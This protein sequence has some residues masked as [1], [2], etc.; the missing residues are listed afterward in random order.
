[1]AD[2]LE[3]ICGFDSPEAVQSVSTCPP[4]VDCP[5]HMWELCAM[6][7]IVGNGYN[8]NGTT[9][10]VFNG[11]PA[12]DTCN[13][14][15]TGPTIPALPFLGSSYAIGWTTPNVSWEGR[16]NF[17]GNPFGNSAP[18]GFQPP[19][20]SVAAGYGPGADG[21]P[22]VS[23]WDFFY[24][25]VVSQVGGN[26][27]IGDRI[28]FDICQQQPAWYVPA[29]S[30]ATHPTSGVCGS[31][32]FGSY[33]QNWNKICLIYKGRKHWPNHDTTTIS[34]MA[35]TAGLD[36]LCCS[37]PSFPST[38]SCN[39][40]AVKGTYPQTRLYNYDA[41]NHIETT[42]GIV[43]SPSDVAIYGNK[44]YNFT[45]GTAFPT[46][47]E[48][49]VDFTTNSLTFIRDIYPAGGWVQSLVGI[50]ECNSYTMKSPNEII[51]QRNSDGLIRVIDIGNATTPATVVSSFTMNVPFN[52][53][54]P[55]GD[56]YYYPPQY[57]VPGMAD[58][59]LVSVKHQTKNFLVHLD[60]SGNIL[61]SLDIGAVDPAFPIT[62][63]DGIYYFDGKT[64]GTFL[65]DPS[66]SYY[67][68]CE[69]S[70]NPLQLST[71]V[72]MNVVG[73]QG[74]DS[75]C[76][77]APIPDPIDP[78]PDPCFEIGDISDPALGGAGGMI[79]ATP[80]SFGNP[81][82]YYYE[83]ALDDLSIGNT[84]LAHST[85]LA[86][87]DAEESCGIASANTAF[88]DFK[89]PWQLPIDPNIPNNMCRWGFGLNSFQPGITN[90]PPIGLPA[91]VNIG[92]PVQALDSNA[93]QIYPPG[94]V[95]EEIH[96]IPGPSAT[97]ITLN[98]GV[99]QTLQ[100]LLQA[101]YL[102]VFNNNAVASIPPFS[103]PIKIL[104]TG[105]TVAGGPF[106]TTGAEW[107]A[108]GQ[109]LQFMPTAFDTGHTNTQDIITFPAAPVWPTHDIAAE[110]CA[111]HQQLPTGY[112]PEKWFLPSL[113]E[114]DLMFQNVGPATPFGVTLQLQQ[115]F[116]DMQDVY[117]TSSDVL[118][119]GPSGTGF[120][121]AWAYCTHDPMVPWPI[122]TTPP[123]P[124]GPFMAKRCSTL[125]VRPIR[126]FECQETIPAEPHP[127]RYQ[128]CD[129]FVKAHGDGWYKPLF[130]ALYS[131]GSCGSGWGTFN[132]PYF[133]KTTP[134][135]RLEAVIG[136]FQYSMQLMTTD[137]AGNQY[138]LSDFDDANNPDG[139]TISIWEADGTYLGAWHYQ[140]VVF[141]TKV[142]NWLK[143]AAITNNFSWYDQIPQLDDPTQV[144]SRDFPD[145]MAIEFAN[146]THVDG[147]HEIVNYGY[148][149]KRS[150]TLTPVTDED[151]QRGQR[152]VAGS[153]NGFSG[154]QIWNE[155]GGQGFSTHHTNYVNEYY[156][157]A[158][159]GKTVSHAYIQI[160]CAT[161][162][163]KPNAAPSV[164]LGSNTVFQHK[165][166]VCAKEVLQ[167]LVGKTMF[168]NYPVTN[169]NWNF[170]K[171][172]GGHI[173]M[174]GFGGGMGGWGGG[175]A[176][177]FMPQLNP[178]GNLTFNLTYGDTT[179]NNAPGTAIN[180]QPLDVWVPNS[181]ILP[182]NGNDAYIAYTAG[183]AAAAADGIYEGYPKHYLFCWYA[184][185]PPP[186]S[187][188]L[189]LYSNLTTALDA[190]NDPNSGAY[191][192]Q[193]Q[194]GCEHYE[195]GD[196]GPAGGIIVAV[197]YMNIN[198]PATGTVGPVVAPLQGD[199][200]VQ[201][202]TNY[203]YE[204]S[205]VNLNVEDD[206][207][208]SPPTADY[209]SWGSYDGFATIGGGSDLLST[210]PIDYTNLWLADMTLY[211]VPT[212]SL[213][214]IVNGP[215]GVA[216]ELVGQ[217]EIVH[218][219]MIFAN[220][221]NPVV[222][223]SGVCNQNITYNNETAFKACEIY[224]LNGYSDWF[225]PSVG[226]M[227]F[228][229]NYT[230]PGTLYDS[231]ATGVS[232]SQSNTWYDSNAQLQTGSAHYWTCNS[233]G[234]NNTDHYFEQDQPFANNLV[235]YNYPTG[236]LWWS[237]Y[238]MQD[239]TWAGIPHDANNCN[240]IAYSVSLDPLVF[241]NPPA[242]PD[243]Q[244]WK[245][246]SRRGSQKH[247]IRAMRKFACGSPETPPGIEYSF[248]Y[249]SRWMSYGSLEQKSPGRINALQSDSVPPV[250]PPIFDPS[251]PGYQEHVIGDNY[252]R[253]HASKYDVVGNQ[254]FV[255][256][257][258]LTNNMWR[259]NG[260]ADPQ[261]VKFEVYSQHEEHLGTWDYDVTGTG[262]CGVDTCSLAVDLTLIS[263]PV[264]VGGQTQVNLWSPSNSGPPGPHLD[265]PWM[266]EYCYIKVT[267]NATRPNNNYVGMWPPIYGDTADLQN[268]LG[269]GV[270]NRTLPGQSVSNSWRAICG[271]CDEGTSYSNQ[272]CE[273]WFAHYVP[274]GAYPLNAS[275]STCLTVNT[276]TYCVPGSSI[277]DPNDGESVSL[278]TFVERLNN[279][280]VAYWQE[281]YKNKSIS[282]FLLPE[283]EKV[284][285]RGVEEEIKEKIE[286]EEQKEKEE[287]QKEQEQKEKEKQELTKEKI[288][289]LKDKKY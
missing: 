154:T 197:P 209:P 283:N 287:Q 262:Q 158:W 261:T 107:G 212:G 133:N 35:A 159:G 64:V 221:S 114:F 62:T 275:L 248:R 42:I 97:S 151:A 78:R 202:P 47:K 281:E 125:S 177:A 32:S 83:V 8:A 134:L 251:T 130:S 106:S 137:V 121:Y 236:G 220:G 86:T 7:E 203:Y 51:M 25:W 194:E 259:S 253:F 170:N 92:D 129:A 171:K 216:S 219:A 127:D 222:V 44:V 81:T 77:D 84:P 110:L 17:H 38:A 48:Y 136:G 227:D 144:T 238:V 189:T 166:V 10:T 140:N 235:S 104:S 135:H 247:N 239:F 26:L 116:E 65:G 224:N 210:I 63:T 254:W 18:G 172:V 182:A 23:I 180:P 40:V 267:I 33:G 105:G 34:K 53:F 2:E 98:S 91:G 246:A 124:T 185:Y 164:S 161:F 128:F 12:P 233:F 176:N 214:T 160:D 95:I 195:V 96:L 242:T 258:S 274:T 50:T 55:A 234:I 5:S 215:I 218:D 186:A 146:V 223:W 152:F 263:Q 36:E 279:Q 57:T 174:G 156:E 187:T 74:M 120:H 277:V 85:V 193:A 276:G 147:P 59:L 232:P 205:P 157:M 149:F 204:L 71:S 181:S 142:D 250:M 163:A 72:S 67:G 143:S 82:P 61:D 198:D 282:E 240:E 148:S 264:V 58:T 31:S 255:G 270:N 169:N 28:V 173:G 131:P 188:T 272:W 244:G 123:I 15:T 141:K 289:K 14:P 208:T 126:K 4:G 68:K 191:G 284:V 109:P 43:P 245:T 70:F 30:G 1:M 24:D 113:D 103:Q 271:A 117:W 237:N 280:C 9:W 108:Y 260:P 196:I 49:E 66:S 11:F 6:H 150:T 13:L 54:L 94:T 101:S 111:N 257:S 76:L 3:D 139:Y 155:L 200:Y 75:N 39:V 285:V 213:V 269:S 93:M 45:S 122:T 199:I 52:D 231:T 225:L 211:D 288:E 132:M 175:W 230:T 56:M 190:M 268:Y 60:M 153:W 29:G 265:L 16:F 217:G 206:C 249:T 115:H 79:F 69:I 168:K 41:V 278:N 145:K 89:C 21:L 201:N 22:N 243:D 256:G 37:Y 73:F 178:N 165:N 192:C 118:D 273:E 87:N 226:E 241:S 138:D 112:P 19:W 266:N 184:D 46:L 88:H 90:P 102:F 20:I 167:S 183:G 229:R 162:N 119:G 252:M 286:K 27:S 80:F 179:V 228:A 207:T 100:P 99:V